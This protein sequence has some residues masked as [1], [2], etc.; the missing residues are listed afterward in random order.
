MRNMFT[1]LDLTPMSIF[2]LGQDIIILWAIF[3]LFINTTIPFL[4]G[5]CV[6]RLRCGFRSTEVVFL[7]L[8][9]P[10]SSLSEVVNLE[11]VQRL[12]ACSDPNLAYANFHSSL[13]GGTS[14]TIAYS[15]IQD[16]YKLIDSGEIDVEE[17][18]SVVWVRG[19]G[20]WGV[21]QFCEA[22]ESEKV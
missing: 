12:V 8:P 19:T 18:D 10:D 14:C 2:C 13:T 21:C 9:A 7:T 11:H 6:L 4:F 3:S 17:L 1:D 5:E 20:V 15:V 22:E 16:A